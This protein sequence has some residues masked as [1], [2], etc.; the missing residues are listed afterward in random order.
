ML[1]FLAWSFTPLYL[2]LLLTVSLPSWECQ[3]YKGQGCCL[4]LFPVGFP[5]TMS[6]MHTVLNKCLLND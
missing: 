6:I 3:F 4:F 5:S 1:Y 2:F